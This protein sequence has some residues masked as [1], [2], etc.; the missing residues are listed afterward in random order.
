MVWICVD[1]SQ[2]WLRGRSFKKDGGLRDTQHILGE[3]GR[4]DG[5]FERGFSKNIDV[6]G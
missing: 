6:L 5:G 4:V 2:I 1:G 3:L